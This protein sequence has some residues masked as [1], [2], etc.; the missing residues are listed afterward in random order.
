MKRRRVR[1]DHHTLPA[2]RARAARRQKGL[3]YWCKQPM[4]GVTA[5]HLIPLYAGG[6]TRPGNIVAA[7]A[8]CNNHRH[9]ELN[10]TK[11]LRRLTIGDDKPT[12][13]FEVIAKRIK[14]KVK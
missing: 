14:E 8:K 6:Q 1:N 7:C 12:S 13:P 10:R 11:E 4:L 3:C 2:L 5:D 9:P